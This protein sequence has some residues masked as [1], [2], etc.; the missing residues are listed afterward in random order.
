[1]EE[2]TAAATAALATAGTFHS[3]ELEVAKRPGGR[4]WVLADDEDEEEAEGGK[5]VA[6]AEVCSSHSAVS[7][8][9]GTSDEESVGDADA[10]P[11]TKVQAGLSLTNRVQAAQRPV[12][13]T[14]TLAPIRPWLGPIPKV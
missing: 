14:T 9:Q 12:F 5:I 10:T 3:P 7:F 11:S 4:F 8:F 1:M 13:R 6:T 2:L